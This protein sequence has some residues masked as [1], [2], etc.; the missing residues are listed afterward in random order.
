M[1]NFDLSALALSAVC[2]GNELIYD[3][4]GM[5]SVMVKIPKMTY[6][7]LGLGDSAA[8]HPAFIV[9]GV[10]VDAI[11]ISKYQNVIQNG[12]AYSLPGRDPAVYVNF[13]QA[14]EACEAKGAGWHIM[15]RAEWA[16]IALWCKANGF[17]PWG[18]NNYGKD[19]RET[20]YKA[21]PTYRYDDATLGNVIGRV[22]TGTGP[23]KWSHDGTP[24]G[25]WDLNGNVWEW[26]G[27]IRTVYGELQVLVN[28]NAAD[29]S[30]SQLADGSEWM[31]I[32]GTTGAYITPDGAGTTANSLKLDFISSK[33][34]WV[35]G[36]I[37]NLSDTG[38]GCSFENVSV[39]S[40]VCAAAILMLQALGLYKY[41]TTSGAYESDYFYW[42]NGA[43]E[44]SLLCGGSWH[45]GVSAGLFCPRGDNGREGSNHHVGFRAAFV[46]LPTV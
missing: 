6:A 1:S 40:T 36:A 14:R 2:P 44:R 12:R 34:T 31:A 23:V 21:I 3:D 10:E 45:F 33:F 18:N 11:Y 17:Q 7:Q 13:D 4:K 35:T 16:L 24:S 30:H 25:I 20:T 32:D 15:T 28:N 5:P 19:T 42:N 26:V 46:E 38:R 29:K 8:V 9:N 43:A 27:G 37:S 41:D 22:A 39:D